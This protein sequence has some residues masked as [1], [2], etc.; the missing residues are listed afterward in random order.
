VANRQLANRVTG[1]WT[2][3]P[4]STLANEQFGQW[5]NSPKTSLPMNNLANVTNWPMEL[6]YLF[7]VNCGKFGAFKQKIPKYPRFA[8][9]VWTYSFKSLLISV[10]ILLHK[11]V[12]RFCPIWH[13]FFYSY[14]HELNLSALLRSATRLSS[15]PFGQKLFCVFV[16]F[17][18]TIS[19]LSLMT[20]CLGYLLAIKQVMHFETF[21]KKN[22]WLKNIAFIISLP[23]LA[24]SQTVQRF[25]MGL[26]LCKLYMFL[27]FKKY[28]F[29]FGKMNMPMSESLSLCL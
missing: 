28:F 16:K 5:N 22:V 12:I 26:L 27:T 9:T 6:Y 29:S 2:I 20:K 25:P 3:W 23:V 14:K 7:C 1:Q 15:L 24:I 19:L 21:I 17:Y 8:H 4:M 13:T 18:E 11:D 10:E